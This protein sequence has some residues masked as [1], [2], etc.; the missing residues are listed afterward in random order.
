MRG[1]RWSESRPE[2]EPEMAGAGRPL[3]LAAGGDTCHW[4]PGSGRQ[5]AVTASAATPPPD[6]CA[7]LLV[8]ACAGHQAFH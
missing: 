8:P 4:Y 5:L 6:R 1:W 7:A 2:P 3:A